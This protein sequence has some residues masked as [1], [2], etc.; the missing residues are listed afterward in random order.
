MQ[1]REQLTKQSEQYIHNQS[2]DE[3]LSVSVV[4][5]VEYSPD[6]ALKRKVTDALITKIDDS[7]ATAIYVGDAIPSSV[8][9]SAVWRIQK[10]AT[11]GATTSVL[12]ADG[13]DEFDNV[14]DNRASLSYS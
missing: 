4:L 3:E 2:F 5:P 9:S 10:I 7:D 11:S 14:W 1:K 13:D 6:G 12:F 8:T